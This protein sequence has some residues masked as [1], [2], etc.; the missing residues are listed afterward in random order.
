VGRLFTDREAWDGGDYELAIHFDGHS[1]E[2]LQAALET[3]W[4]HE[5]LEGPYAHTDLEPSEQSVVPIA[6]NQYGVAR[7]PGGSRVACGVYTFDH[8]AQGDELDL[9]LPMGSLVAAWPAVRGYPFVSEEEVADMRSWQEPL[10]R[11]LLDVG[12]HVAGTVPFVAGVTGWE[13]VSLYEDLSHWRLQGVPQRRS[14]GLLWRDAD[15]R[16]R[17]YPATDTAE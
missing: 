17:W 14:F 6:G 13:T 8:D 3:L 4:S 11:W 7:L 1:E 16:V 15:G 9:C 12:L 2:R 10:D 5:D